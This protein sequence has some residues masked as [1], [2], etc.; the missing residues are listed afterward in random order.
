M[1]FTTPQNQPKFFSAGITNDW[2]ANNTWLWSQAVKTHDVFTGANFIPIG[3]NTTTNEVTWWAGWF[4]YAGVKNILCNIVLTTATLKI[5]VTDASG[6]N[7]HTNTSTPQT[8]TSLNLSAYSFVA[9]NQY[10]VRLT[11]THDSS[12]TGNVRVDYMAIEMQQPYTFPTLA[13]WTNGTSP[14]RA[15]WDDVP[16]ALKFLNAL[17]APHGCSAYV[18]YDGASDNSNHVFYNGGF[19]YRSQNTLTIT[20]SF[21]STGTATLKCYDSGGTLRDTFTLTSDGSEHVNEVKTLTGSYTVNTFCRVTIE[22]NSGTQGNW[23]SRMTL[24]GVAALSHNPPTFSHLDIVYGTTTANRMYY[25][26]NENLSE[27]KTRLR[28]ATNTSFQFLSP[29]NIGTVRWDNNTYNAVHLS[30]TTYDIN[31]VVRDGSG[32]Y[33][34]RNRTATYLYWKARTAGASGSINY[35]TKVQSLSDTTNGSWNKFNLSGIKDLAMG[36]QITVNDV[37]SAFEADS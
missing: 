37:L 27:I 19:Y 1:P 30:G 21:L 20:Y 11:L 23:V 25:L 10:R 35:G 16:T 34:I 14:A 2:S 22:N 32:V 4:T 26:A 33:C 18:G 7:L 9:G 17:V 13:A 15:T 31:N 3:G 24:G 28:G 29:E 5:Y 6:E 8:I 12:T 36:Q